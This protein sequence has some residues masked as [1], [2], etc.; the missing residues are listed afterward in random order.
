MVFLSLS[1]RRRIPSAGFATHRGP[2]GFGVRSDGA[3]AAITV[4][5]CSAGRLGRI[6]GAGRAF[7]EQAEAVARHKK[8][9]IIV[10]NGFGCLIRGQS[11]MMRRWFV[12][13]TFYPFR[14]ADGS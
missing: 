14:Q 2:G 5:R 4:G 6:C 3:L 12:Y 9:I 11:K 13:I 8:S 10:H 7:F 1:M